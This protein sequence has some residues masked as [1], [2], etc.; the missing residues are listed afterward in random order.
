MLGLLFVVSL[1]GTCS[2][3]IKENYA[4]T[5][6]AENWANK[7]L[8]YKDIMD[9]VSAEERM[10]NLKNGKYKQEEVYPE[11]HRN[12]NGKIVIENYS[13]YNDDYKKHGALQTM[14]WAEQGKYNLDA[15]E[16]EV[17]RKKIKLYYECLCN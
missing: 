17:E 3:L 2:Q 13:L 5:I 9:G 12:A 16:L 10:K 1:I 15:E 7:E 4:S 14:K 8:Y 6:P 11:P